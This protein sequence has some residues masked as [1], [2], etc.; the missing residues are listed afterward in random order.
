ML[1]RSIRKGIFGPAESPRLWLERLRKIMSKLGFRELWLLTCV[2]VIQHPDGRLRAIISIHVDDCL[3]AGDMTCQPP[4]DA[5]KVELMFGSWHLLLD[6]V[7]FLGRFMQQAPLP[8]GSVTIDLK[9]YTMKVP[10]IPVASGRDLDQ[11]LSPSEQSALRSANGSVGFAAKNGR[12]DLA[13]AVSRCQ[14]STAT[15]TGHT[16]I[17]AN[18][19]IKRLRQP[20]EWHIVPLGCSIWDMVVVMP[21]DASQGSKIGRA[22]V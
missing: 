18:Q 11:P 10:L 22:H 13:F 3:G 19:A 20:V 16:L 17:E 12:H 21:S 7:K 15:A 14:Q 6:G 1:F 4:W 2:F 8:I 9:E 5:L